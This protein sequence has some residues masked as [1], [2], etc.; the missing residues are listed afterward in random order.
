[1]P[2]KDDACKFAAGYVPSPLQ[3]GCSKCC[4]ALA[5]AEQISRAAAMNQSE[6]NLT[7]HWIDRERYAQVKADPTYPNGIDLDFSQ[8]DSGCW[9]KLPYPTPR[10][11]L[12]HIECHKCGSD[13]LVTTAGR[14]DD[15]RSV[16]LKCTRINLLRPLGEM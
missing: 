13:A 2:T 5:R 4:P 15:P 16:K 7:V 14:R 3:C 9:T 6:P 12:F 11:G 10:C 8:G 1:M